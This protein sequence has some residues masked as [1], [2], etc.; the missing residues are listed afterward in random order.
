MFGERDRTQMLENLRGQRVELY[1][2]KNMLFFL[3]YILKH[4]FVNKTLG[5][6]RRARK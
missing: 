5:F 3:L 4:Y 2:K 1:F 6:C